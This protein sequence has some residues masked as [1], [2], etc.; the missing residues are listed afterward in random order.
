MLF[1]VTKREWSCV[2]QRGWR[3]EPRWSSAICYKESSQQLF[4]FGGTGAKGACRAE[5]FCCELD[6]ERANH[7]LSELQNQVKDLDIVS[8]RMK[9]LFAVPSTNMIKE[10]DLDESFD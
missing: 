7:R 3:P 5:V 4:V 10:Q 9:G 8:K 6:S 2:A 1:N